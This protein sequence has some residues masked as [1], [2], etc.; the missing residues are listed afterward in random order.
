MKLREIM[1][2]C[3]ILCC[4]LSLQTV[5][6]ADA[7]N[8]DT[9]KTLSAS[10]DDV[11][12]ESDGS[13]SLS[14]S[15]DADVLADATGN[16]GSFSDLQTLINSNTGTITLT[17][18]YTYGGSDTGNAGISIKN[19]ITI[20]GQ[21]N[22]VID[23][24]EKSRIFNIDKS[25]VTLKG[26]TL[27]NGKT[28]ANGGAITSNSA[29]TIEYC[30]VVNNTAASGGAIYSS[31][32]DV[33]MNH[34]S[35][36][37]NNAI[38]TEG[39]TGGGV[40]YKSNS[41]A[42]LI[43]DDCEVYS[44]SA[45][46]TG[47]AICIYGSEVLINNSYFHN[48]YAISHGGDFFG[49]NQNTYSFTAYNS[50]FDSS[51]TT[52]GYGGSLYFNT[53]FKGVATINIDRCNFTNDYA[54]YGGGAIRFMENCEWVY[55]YNC[56]FINC[57]TTNEGGAI[58]QNKAGYNFKFVNL[59]C[60]NC[61]Q[62]GGPSTLGG[63][64]ITFVCIYT[65]LV[66]D[67][68][69]FINCSAGARGGGLMYLVSGDSQYVTDNAY[70]KDLY[71]VNCT[72]SG[73]GGG[74][75]ATS[76]VSNSHPTVFANA[77]IINCSK[78]GNYG[79]GGGAIYWSD[80]HSTLD[81]ITIINSSSNSVGGAIYL[82]G[83]DTTLKNINI[84]N[85]KTGTSGGAIYI[86]ATNCNIVNVNVT[87][88]KAIDGG[89]IYL[90]AN[91]QSLTK[92]TINNASAER[93][94]GGI[95]VGNS[96][97]IYLNNITFNDSHAYNGGAL[98]YAGS[99][100]ALMWMDNCTFTNN[101]ASHNGGA[102][103]YII[104]DDGSTKKVSRDYNNFDGTGI[105][106]GGR[107]TVNMVGSDGSTYAKRIFNSYFEN[108]NDYI[109]NV[110]AMPD[111]STIMGIV[112]VSSPNDPN[113]NSYRLVVNVTSD[114]KLVT[115]LILSTT[116]D[117]TAYF[118]NVFKKFIIGIR[119]NLTKDTF[120]NVT[121]GF[122]DS[123]Y[124]YK[125][126][127]AN[128][129]T[130][131]RIDKGDFHILQ[132]L[133]DKAIRDAPAGIPAVLNLPRSFEFMSMEDY[134]ALY[135][136]QWIADD[137]CMN[138]TSPITINGNGY[139]ISALGYSRIFNITG[140]D[141]VLNNVN[142]LYGNAS[143]KYWDKV[144]KGGA[145]FW[146]GENG[147]I[148]AST[149][150]YN[151][152]EYGAG[153]YLNLT[154]SNA[155]IA[156]STFIMNN[157]TKN[158][159]AI[160]CNAPEM[161]LTNTRF[162]SNYADTGAALCREESA[163][164]GFGNNNIFVS[165]N[166]VSYGAALAWMKS[167][168][169]NINHYTFIDNTAGISGGAIFVGVGSGNCVVNNSYFEGNNVTDFNDGHGGAIE[170]YADN[171][172]V[173]NSTFINNNA[174]NG[175]AIFVGDESKEINITD[176]NFTTNNA[177]DNGGAIN[178]EGSHVT[179]N[180]TRF[181]DNTAAVNGGALYM[182]GV[183]VTN[184]IYSSVFE[185][186]N[187][188]GYGGAIDW[189]A[190]AGHIADSNFTNNSADYGGAIYLN[191][192]SSKSN[193]TNVIFRYNNATHNGGA[194]DCNATGMNL[195]YTLFEY[196][197]AGEY[198]AAL[199]R[200]SNA[201]GGHGHHNVFN[202]NHAEIAGAALA[203]MNVSSININYYNFTGNT[204]HKSGGAIYAAV[205]SDNFTIN[206]CNF[207]SNN[208][209]NTT[210]GHGGAIDISSDNNT[211]KNSNF[212][213]NN[214]FYGGALFVGSASGNTNITNSIFT[215]NNAEIDGGAINLQSSG[216]KLNETHFFKNTAQ[217]NGGAL[218]VG[219]EGTTNVIYN[220][221]FDDN[222]AENNGGAI[223]WRAYAGHIAY[224]NFTSNDAIYG[225]AIFLNGVSSNTNIT[226]VIFKYNNAT[227][228]GGAIECNATR[229]N[230][231]YTLFD[232]NYAGE[233]G[234]ALCREVGATSGF[235]EY[236]NFTSN[237]AGI[238]GAALAWM[239]VKNIN[240][241][242]YIFTDNTADAMGGA[243]YASKGSDNFTINNCD[244]KGNNITNGTGGYGGAIYSNSN[245]NTI[246][247]SNFTNNNAF[248]G[249][250]IYVGGD[251]GHTNVTNV[252]FDRNNAVVDGGAIN[253]IA[254]GVRLNDTR[255]YNNTAQRNGGAVYV[256][257]DGTTNVVYNSGFV[258]NKA[259]SHGGAIDWRASAGEVMNTNFLRNSAEYGGAIYLN[260]VSTG[261][262]IS[263]VYFGQN[264]ASKNGGAIDC[265]A[266]LMNL[267]H[268]IFF[269]NRADEYGAA[270]CRESQATGGF[271]LNNTFDKN[272]AGISGAALAW[273][274]VDDIK[275]NNYT[276]TN[277]TA[278]YSGG[279]IYVSAGSDN[280]KVYN[281]TF[282]DNYISNAIDGR[283]G[284]IDW[285]GNNGGVEN[286]TFKRCISVNAGGIYVG[287]ESHNMY[288]Q[289]V[290]FTS[291]ESL[292]NGGAIVIAGDN[293]TV[294]NSNFTSSVARDNGG[295]I[296][297]M[298]SDNGNITNCTFKYNVV[299]GHIDPQGNIYGEGGAIYWENSKNL[300]MYNNSFETNA[301]RLSGG[302][303]SADN[304]SDSVIDKMRT[305]DETAFTD[306]G[307]I[308][309]INSDNV[310]IKNGFFNDSGSNYK[311]G[312]LYF[313]NVN[314]TVKDTII[315]STWA[316][317]GKGGAI[318]VA[319]NVKIDKVSFNDTHS[320]EDNATAIYFESGISSV[321]NS[322]FTG[323]Y[324]SIGIQRG[325]NVTLTKNN[326]TASDPNK[327]MMY[328]KE[329]T[330]YAASLVKY[331][332]W[333][334]GDLY[335]DQN[336][337]DYVIFNNGTIWTKTTTKMLNNGSH[338]VDW[339][340]PFVFFANITD[341]NL[342]TIISVSSLK[343]TNDVYQDVGAFYPL[344]YN[345]DE[346]VCIYQGVFHL[347]PI[348]EGLKQNTLF[349][350][351]LKVKMPVNLTVDAV[352]DITKEG[353]LVNATLQPVV[354]SNFTIKNQNVTFNIYD[355]HGNLIKGGFN[356]TITNINEKSLTSGRM[357]FTTWTL[358]N[359]SKE[360]KERLIAGTYRLT[361]SYGG[362]DVHKAVENFT[363]FTINLRLPYLEL[364]VENIYWGQNATVIVNTNGTGQVLLFINGKT[365]WVDIV[366]GRAEYNETGL[367]PG[368][369]SVVVTYPG[370]GGRYFSSF[371][372]GK[373]F[374]VYKLNT[375]IDATPTTP[376]TVDDLEI[377][378]VEVNHTAGGFAKITINGKDY[379]AIVESGIATFEIP[380]LAKGSYVDIPVTFLG[381]TH[382]KQNSTKTAFVVGATD[383]YNIT[384]HADNI[385]YGQNATIYIS[386]PTSVSENLTV[387]INNDIYENVTVVNGMANLTVPNL[388]VGTYTVNVTY[389]GDNVYA[390]K[391]KNG[392][393]FK[394]T[395]SDSYAINVTA[396][397][398]KVDQ[399]TTITVHVPKDAKGNV[400]IWVNGT[401]KV[402]STIVDGVVTFTLNKTEAGKYEVN[403]TLSDANYANKTAYADYYVSKFETPIDISV[404][405]VKV[406]DQVEIT[407]T[408]PKGVLNNVTI[409][410]AGKAYNKTVDANGKAVFTVPSLVNT[411][412]T[413]VATYDGDRKYMF[414]S[415]TANFTI[416]KRT[417]QLN[418][419]AVGNTVGNNA[420]ITVQAESNAT[421][422]VN[423]DINGTV[424]S[425]TLN[426]TGGGKLNVTG[427]GNGTY[428][429][430]AT[431][432]GDDQ[433]MAGANN[434]KTFE[435][436][437]SDVD[438]TIDV[439][440]IDY[441]QK[442]N[443][444]VTVSQGDATGFITIR[445][446]ETR[447][448]TLPIGN[449]KVSWIVDGLAADNYT[450]YANYSG[451]GKYNINN[452]DGIKETFEVR[453]ITPVI[454]IVKVISEAGD[455][456]TVIVRID[457]RTTE[458]INVNV[459][460]DY[461]KEIGSGV[462]VITTDKLANGTYTV[463]ASYIG[464][465]NFTK[466]SVT[467]TFT[468]NKTSGYEL[469]IT[470]GDIKVGDST[471]IV[472]N[473]PK[474]AEG[475]VIVEIE[476]KN[477][478]AAIKDGK[479]VFNNQTNL[480]AGKYNITAYF[481]ND[482]YANR[483]ATGV[484]YIN[485]FDAPISIDVDD[486]KV[487]DVA[488]INVTA[489]SGDVTIEINGKSYDK[490]KYENGIAY[491]EV[492]DLAYGNKTVVAIY[493]GNDKYAINATTENFTVSKRVSSVNVTAAPTTVG[494]DLEINVTIPENATGYVIVT[495][496]GNNYTVNT[497]DGNG[498]L[499]IKG[500]EKGSY[501]INVTYIGDEQYLSNINSTD[502]VISQL[503]SSVN[504]TVED[505]VFGDVAI[506]NI[507]VLDDATGSVTVKVNNTVVTVG[508]VDGR[509]IA[510]IPNLK[511]GNY[512]VDITYNGD[513]KYEIN[514]NSTTFE[515][516][517][518]NMTEADITVVDQGNGT[519]VVIVPGNATGNVTI[520]VNGTN[521]TANVT[522]G[523]A[524]ITLENVTPGEHNIT[525][526]Y[527]GDGNY[528]SITTNATVVIPR[529]ETPIDVTAGNIYVGDTAN[530]RVELPENATGRITIEINGKVYEPASFENG[531]AVFEVDNLAYGD[532][533]VA[534]KYYGDGNYSSNST[535]ANFTVSKRV[536]SVNVT[537][538]P[539]TV[540]SDLEINVTIPENATGYV[541]VSVGGIDFVVNTTDGNGILVIKGFEK[542]DYHI[543][544]TYI[545]DDQYLP[546]INSTDVTV[547]K[548]L[549]S[550]NVTV[551][552]IGSG[553]AVI[554][555]EV[556]DDATGNVTIKVNETVVTV[557]IVDGKAVAVVPNLE[558]GNYTVKVTYNG[559]RKYESSNNDTVLEIKKVKV[560]SDMVVID[561]G[562]G[563][564]VVV[565]GDNATG[566][567][568]IK[569][570]ENEYN[571]TVINGTAIV[572]I[573]NETPG[574]HEVEVI[575]SG[576]EDH[577][578]TTQDTNITVP[579]YDTE[580]N[581]TVGEAK[582]GEPVTITVE[583]P[584]NAT[585]NV[586]V[587][588]DG[589]EYPGTV[590]QGKAV[591]TVDSLTAG[592][593]TVTVEYHGDDN[594]TANYTI[595]TFTVEKAKVV[596]DI[597]VVDQGNGTVVVVVGDNAT[598]NVTVKVGDHEYNA[599][600]VNGTA[601]VNVDNET[602]GV[603][604]IEV[605]YSGDD[606][607]T[608]ATETANITAPKYDTGINV[609][610]GEA[611]E[612]EP[613]T[614]TVEVPQNATGDVI[615]NVGGQNYTG[616]IENGKAVVTVENVSAGNHTIAVEYIGDD[617][618][619]DNYS[620][621]KVTVEPAKVTPD[622]RVIDQGN[623]TVV[624]VVGD[625]ATGNVTIKV[626][627]K[628]YNA[629]VV[630]GT[631]V[632]TLDNI[633]P[634]EQN[635]TVVY[636]GDDT[637][638]ATT[639]NATVVGPKYDAPVDVNVTKDGQTATITVTVPENATGN[640][641]VT[642][643][644]H[645]YPGTIENGKAVVT[646]DNLTPGDKT[647]IVEYSGD[648]NYASN[649]TISN[650]TIDQPKVDSD[651]KVIDQGNGTIVVVVGDNATG[652][653][654]VTV[655]G[656]NYTAEVI[657]GTAVVTLDNVT[658]GTHEI[659]VVY[660]GDDTH[661]NATANATI[662]VSKR[663]TPISI[664]VDDIKVGDKAIIKVTVRQ[665]AAGDVTIEID[666]K[667]Y[668]EK[669][670]DGVAT[671][672]I[673]GLIAGNKSVFAV[674]NGDEK[675]EENY[676]SEQFDVGKVDS[677][678]T[679]LVEDINVGE[680]VTITVN[681]PS[682]AT[683]QVL[684][685]ID[686]VGYY[687]N[688]T[689]GSGTIEI[690]RLAA[691]EYN[692]T[693][694]YTG[695]D[696]Y[697]SSSNSTTVK[698]SKL[699]SFVIP[700]AHNIYV[701]EN[702][703]IHLLVPED[704]T[705][706][707]TVIIDGEEYNFNL[708]NG[709]LGA[710]YD[711]GAK[712]NVAISAGNGELVISGL[713]KGEYI[714]SVKYNG[715]E[716]YLPAV[717]TTMFTV[718]KAATPMDVVDQGNG[719]V[720]VTVPEDATGTV[721]VTVDN[722]TYTADVVDGKAVITLE[723]TTPGKHD[724]KV[725]Y[726][727]D[728]EYSSNT[729]NSIVEIPKYDTPIS[730]SVEDINVGDTEIVT[731][732]VP[733]DAAGTVT[734]EI[735]GVEYTADVSNGKAV[736]NVDGLAFGE[737]TVAVKYSG[738]DSYN[739]NFTTAQFTVS[740]VPSTTTATGKDIKV[741]KD[742]VITVT[743]PRD[744]TGRVLVD[745]DGIGYYGTIVNGKANVVIPELYAGKYTAKVTYDG[746][747]K[748]LPST[749]TVKFTVTKSSA[750]ISASGDDIK[751]G[752]DATVI[753]HVPSDATGTITITVD[754]K[755][756]TNPVENGKA[757]FVI[758]GLTKGD[759]DITAVYSGDKRY[760][761]NDTITDIEVLYNETPDDNGEPVYGGDGVNLSDYPTGNPI[762]ILLLI[763]LTIGST[764]IRRFK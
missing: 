182:G 280:C 664:D 507:T 427:L 571:A 441:G 514:T 1:V 95:Y 100:G 684:I 212:T 598:G 583:V 242:H 239:N 117:F 589:K 129:T 729:T 28:S 361:A 185:G 653:V 567:V 468:T 675:Y 508:I 650:F 324:N 445:I 50:S 11:V 357:T 57:T 232:T 387:F 476:G 287:E 152:A 197:Y 692:V 648:D 726:S 42:K 674:Y 495:I 336:N 498:T 170:W 76:M 207:E 337:F 22:I 168:K 311:G 191:G 181:T 202:Y 371:G 505:I 18:N 458:T 733:E 707:V 559:D 625:N 313:E 158:G 195:T 610:V 535:T 246:K 118:N 190:S 688:V 27:A 25:T 742:E 646:V 16:G 9:N 702:E 575:Y 431:Y 213:N 676:T 178:I 602:P 487:G 392:T 466:A 636:S 366:D 340:D 435:M 735:N 112:N 659:E 464:D 397:D 193:I 573:G 424:Y 635:I 699:E 607:H 467:E 80:P 217:R 438:L 489:P 570:G 62:T 308:A 263:R 275:I 330:T 588:I 364:I 252:T 281:S 615:V 127:V 31:T 448:I 37:N 590:E 620:V 711:E 136:T 690:P 173:L 247:N 734:I 755:K 473:V 396:V 633:T 394:V 457:P 640:V 696:K 713:P 422:Y 712:Y 122:E 512:T 527:S 540:G 346:I 552:D 289:N 581:I 226:H 637:H 432:A 6:A 148:N 264:T 214:A 406:G 34:S 99:V 87:N 250:A 542:G 593:K 658:P 367:E 630:N 475:I 272:H 639:A 86:G 447:N 45:Q 482:K 700:T 368:N 349:N 386:L 687:I 761:A 433:Y 490:V 209:T 150:A 374:E 681:V 584:Q 79:Y 279:A 725:V 724:V 434:D 55:V 561:Q 111:Q 488:Y 67:N 744:A 759:H 673:E 300:T 362:D 274:D 677:K 719:T 413:V 64:A 306:G 319:G 562:N 171:G 537:A 105:V 108:N 156:N 563:T 164:G 524:V 408:V 718:S 753:V 51:K 654:T 24:K 604:E 503:P 414:N 651:V 613:F 352:V 547:A 177:Y 748:Y 26:I 643:D 469:N 706:T 623:G 545:G 703:N 603:H 343:A 355:L 402:N 694:T 304:V 403:A 530:I 642:I 316:S 65:S 736:F 525:V 310:T 176:S 472:V 522:N 661:N 259:N 383:D 618:Y 401:K 691:G 430:H 727:G 459:D 546:N 133:I 404:A 605:I 586:T 245:D 409:E 216:V 354:K 668:T 131:N 332:V 265:N 53:G 373:P 285:V 539:T 284:A 528:T 273:L 251:S 297:G 188:T 534:V 146:A 331:A 739:E 77:T 235:G 492:P 501:P 746:D 205:G 741:G 198:G 375:T 515:V 453:Q 632:V 592:N 560:E 208:V 194:I 717:N 221:E 333:N 93:Y 509:A 483:T 506:V 347:K 566:N 365:R 737:K 518:V 140:N 47:G 740:K 585:G 220:S 229:M 763:V 436:T 32:G 627:D 484:F 132:D 320:D 415:T 463:N 183:G 348:D 101:N 97:Y 728:D 94:G 72:S 685:D 517:K 249:G 474:D 599:T 139:S 326:L 116:E 353:I 44:N 230:L 612:G 262:K 628:E 254:S 339:N 302:S 5:M 520:Y 743:V 90:D 149:I 107:T 465:K 380:D 504:V 704:A 629:T 652:N 66:M 114:D 750:P 128:F 7:D 286:T 579:K 270:L 470:A 329:N 323:S 678:L 227:K 309:W 656:Q 388:P 159:G 161:N 49:E 555:V 471:D 201:T 14:V 40:I 510:V 645:E 596:S 166:A 237:H 722:K 322:N 662:D 75:F 71:F 253:L 569:V 266:T 657:N 81:N 103:Y 147:I 163:T 611:K 689:D 619:N 145:I 135:G 74:A 345:A 200:E 241:N 693:L 41:K 757:I 410:I 157:A 491:F 231:T 358:A 172:L 169:I 138:I 421:G 290:S 88:S 151:N 523:T 531:V 548:L 204:A 160:D 647:V 407:V 10:T 102:I 576:D 315:N 82:T 732:T 303:I 351:T 142:L 91:Y 705:G 248:N 196:N 442:A 372:T 461:I 393:V 644:G 638:N 256:G 609:T 155:K 420:T 180:N 83:L 63:G 419:T 175:G 723:N 641:T 502:V 565:I 608:N 144:N 429:V 258:D 60:I 70:Y 697:L 305:H 15:N 536:S 499:I 240:I 621:S 606:T 455:N 671:F 405:P 68:I 268:T 344:P 516:K 679:V 29:L 162:E 557:G 104:D 672:E 701:G 682:D 48:N 399:N 439:A 125:E 165:N 594:Y 450:V 167:Q 46:V 511:V 745:I 321:S 228:N 120:Y 381:D 257:G 154:A 363:T 277:N 261:S 312:T 391:D 617:N 720:V 299:G 526:V 124:L 334:E 462:I 710:V 38:S 3:L 749:T 384:V 85:T 655:D 89:A 556:L 758:P 30:N 210:G 224:T 631:A 538:A 288:I 454:E 541:I 551:E 747:D 446:N 764:Q 480:P 123:E 395:K 356:A 8:I 369:Y 186:N 314:A 78:L 493:G 335:L 278:D 572:N 134:E 109:L 187:A 426:S 665:D 622:V 54:L 754:G 762:L 243:I 716:K 20:V 616:T 460:K 223:Y 680:N 98:Y 199:C 215:K 206:N 714:V 412:R 292:T 203:W 92:C 58:S 577:N 153:I 52:K 497:T 377:I 624:V 342:N 591:V 293:V 715:D 238:A 271:G 695:D 698:V 113:R 669:V 582:E 751:Q 418:V 174:F 255:F 106:D 295:A 444:T 379:Y 338:E 298:S 649:Y 513:G 282:E 452:G 2:I 686:G 143:G 760:E 301:A 192:I 423:V 752:E 43:F 521:Y 568:T 416:N 378:S 543:D 481:G 456:A 578:S 307:S 500:L 477:Y 267:T 417:T 428:Y 36:Y 411:T 325:A 219:G 12:Q 189:R 130:I 400:T 485:K 385:T 115:Q 708:D 119:N 233:Y 276:F 73:Y 59:T 554:T 479:A 69:K 327:S 222:D 494:S 601:V 328:I 738:D 296:A 184:R 390:P 4:I 341:D 350:G 23:A 595:D 389:P 437:K 294:V 443:I 236:N 137:Y 21:G 549:S 558:V 496:G 532:K 553:V 359:V 283:G 33:I 61:T 260:G 211:I 550:V 670:I 451:D 667:K 19:D 35:F 360:I 709:V 756:Y 683:G 179:L 398:V 519:V 244:F 84:T 291:C 544:V 486:I 141:V 121:V 269:S 580:M 218:Y 126:A 614:I 533:T 234:A 425:I 225:G 440:S 56:Q 96:L 382:F 478:T 13:L 110:T 529:Y 564:V 317:W 597:N 376:I 370:D 634:G 731:V 449:G 39:R 318:Y 721:T 666:G 663:S 600:V 17:G 660:S 574:I 626:G 730:V 587:Y